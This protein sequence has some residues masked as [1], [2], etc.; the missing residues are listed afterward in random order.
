MVERGDCG[1]LGEQCID[2][3]PAL[4]EQVSQFFFPI[5]T[6]SLNGLLHRVLKKLLDKGQVNFVAAGEKLSE[7]FGSV[8]F[9]QLAGLLQI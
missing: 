5:G 8:K 9:C 4:G 3:E 1:D 7:F 6:V 2:V